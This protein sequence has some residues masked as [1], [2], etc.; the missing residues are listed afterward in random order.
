MDPFTPGQEGGQEDLLA[1][2]VEAR[3]ERLGRRLAAFPLRD[4]DLEKLLGLE[5]LED[6][7]E[8]V[9]ALGVR[10][11]NEALHPHERGL[12]GVGVLSR[13]RLIGLERLGFCEE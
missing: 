11:L 7:D 8:A 13:Q 12:E 2:R 9:V 5:L 3:D 4:L 10:L 6:A 1:E